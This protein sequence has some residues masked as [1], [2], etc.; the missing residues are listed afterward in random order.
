M[1]WDWL[2]YIMASGRNELNE[3]RKQL[4]MGADVDYEYRVM[5]EGVDMSFTPLMGASTRGH[6]PAVTLLIES[7]ADVNKPSIIISIKIWFLYR[8]LQKRMDCLNLRTSSGLKP[9]AR[10]EG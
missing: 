3:I 4:R 6:V 9:M 8:L 10:T 7:G 2:L 1:R 5:I